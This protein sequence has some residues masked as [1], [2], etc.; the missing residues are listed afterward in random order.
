MAYKGGEL[1]AE[2]KKTRLNKH[3]QGVKE[4]ALTGEGLDP[5]AEKKLVIV[6]F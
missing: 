1:E 5:A 6:Q 2:L 3:V 4:L